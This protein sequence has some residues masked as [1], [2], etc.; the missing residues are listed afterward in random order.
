MKV[1]LSMCGFSVNAGLNCSIGIPGC[2]R[3][4]KC[5]RSVFF[6]FYRFV[7]WSARAVGIDVKSDTTSKETMISCG[8]M[9]LA[10]FFF[11][12]VSLF[13]SIPTALALQVTKNRLECD[14]T[15]S[16]RTNLSVD[17]I[18]KLLEMVLDNN[19]F[20]FNGAFYKQSRLLQTV[21]TVTAASPENTLQNSTT[22]SIPSTNTSNLL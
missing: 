6:L 3:V 11:D 2:L 14:L 19:F 15:I 16:E 12:V 17:N 7:T 13:T 22:I 18:M 4:E 10:E 9:V 8:S 1:L 20:V 21:T 5:N